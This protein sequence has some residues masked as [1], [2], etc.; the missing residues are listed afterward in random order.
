MLTR[1]AT[2]GLAVLKSAIGLR[3]NYRELVEE[4][5]LGKA[6]CK[7]CAQFA[8]KGVP[9]TQEYFPFTEQCRT[10]TYA[11]FNTIERNV[12][13]NEKN[14]YG[15]RYELKKNALLLFMYLHYLNPDKA[16]LVYVNIEKAAN[17]LKCTE[18]TIKNNLRLLDKHSYI[19]LDKT[20]VYPGLYKMFIS[21][22]N[23]YFLPANKG[24]RGYCTMPIEHLTLLQ[25]ME[26]I[27]G[28]RL[29]IR[30][31]IPETT[32]CHTPQGSRPFILI[33]QDLPSYCS[34]KKILE[35]TSSDVFSKI[36][37]VSS[38]KYFL[39]IRVK[40]AYDINSIVLT[41][42]AECKDKILDLVQQLQQ[43]SK[44]QKSRY[45]LYLLD[46]DIKDICNIALKVPVQFVLDAV[47]SVNTQYIMHGLPVKS[48]GALVRTIAIDAF[49]K[50]ENRSK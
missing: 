18:R 21:E 8:R 5:D 27:N 25:D 3:D 43:D 26:N 42:K 48:M 45:S 34:K 29:A 30:N 24:G 4:I 15:V 14:K 17:T 44:K 22:Y 12:Y 23:T 13:V 37:D 7:R 2:I 40:D 19:V 11:I 16:G 20:P 47:R 46:E 33:Q 39:D 31:L 41:Y 28:L 36:F 6:G 1:T 38:S 9:C 35:I 32:V 10:C 50:Y 49:E